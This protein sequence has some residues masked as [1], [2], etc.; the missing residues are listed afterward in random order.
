MPTSRSM[1]IE[2]AI[3]CGGRPTSSPPGIIT[4]QNAAE[5]VN[6]DSSSPGPSSGRVLIRLFSYV[7]PPRI[8]RLG[9][10]ATSGLARGMAKTEL[11]AVA[12]GP[13]GEA[14]RSRPHL[15]PRATADKGNLIRHGAE[16]VQD[17]VVEEE[18]RPGANCDQCEDQLEMGS[19]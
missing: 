1:P 11:A 14:G 15:P 12:A 18:D 3:S 5:A 6:F 17:E 8:R 9:F 13:L 19:A 2:T 10:L 7:S 16:D 4:Q